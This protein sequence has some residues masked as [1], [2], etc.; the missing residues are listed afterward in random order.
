VEAEKILK[1]I[2]GIGFV[3]FSEIDVVR[4][5]LVQDVIRAYNHLGREKG[6]NINRES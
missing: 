6:K 2:E 3:Y 1:K 4:H 5:H